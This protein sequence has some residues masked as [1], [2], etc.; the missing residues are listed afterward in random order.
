MSSERVSEISFRNLRPR[1]LKVPGSAGESHLVGVGEFVQE[2][3][4]GQA[5]RGGRYCDTVTG[6]WLIDYHPDFD[7]LVVAT[8]DSGQSQTQSRLIQLAWPAY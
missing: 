3:A 8:G 5:D 6:D 1:T 4:E 7:N 2:M